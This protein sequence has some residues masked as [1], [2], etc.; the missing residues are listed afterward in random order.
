MLIGGK[1]I[2][3]I[4]VICGFVVDKNGAVVDNLGALL[5][6]FGAVLDNVGNVSAP[7]GI[8]NVTQK[9]QKIST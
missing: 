8:S 4:G 9:P 2:G 7:F 5:D 3:E 1:N 6:K